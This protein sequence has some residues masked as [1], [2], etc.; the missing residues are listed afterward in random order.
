MTDEEKAKI[1][2][3]LIADGP[4]FTPYLTCEAE[5]AMRRYKDIVLTK[6]TTLEEDDSLYTYIEKGDKV[7]Y[8]KKQG[9]LRYYPT[10]D[11]IKSEEWVISYSSNDTG[12]KLSP[13]LIIVEIDNLFYPMDYLDECQL[14]AESILDVPPDCLYLMDPPTPAMRRVKDLAQISMEELAEIF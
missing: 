2:E 9:I 14:I 1:I 11:N 13:K 4:I 12:N 6:G 8:V 7:L 5:E 3:E 10:L